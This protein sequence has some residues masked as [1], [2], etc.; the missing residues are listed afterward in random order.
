METKI[1][2]TLEVSSEQGLC[3][4]PIHIWQ[5]NTSV[6][7]NNDALQMVSFFVTKCGVQPTWCNI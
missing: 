5:E 3:D 1:H 4:E 7:H 6:F 2:S